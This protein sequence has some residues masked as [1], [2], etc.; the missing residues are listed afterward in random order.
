MI[1]ELT[2]KEIAEWPE[3]FFLIASSP[4]RA[5][6]TFLVNY[7]FSCFPDNYWSAVFCISPT[8]TLQGAF[9][10]VKSEHIVPTKANFG[11]TI[12]RIISFQKARKEANLVLGRVCLILDDLFSS[13]QR[14][15]G[16]G[17]VSGVLEILASRGRHYGISCVLL[18]QR[19]FSIS[20]S[21]RSNAD[22]YISFYPR[23]RK[24]REAIIS[25]YLSRENTGTKADTR[26]RALEVLNFV[27]D[28]KSNSGFRALVVYCDSRERTLEGIC[29]W[30][31]APAVP[32]KWN[33][34]LKH[35]SK[36]ADT[37]AKIEISDLAILE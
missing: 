21:I 4:R 36:A 35:V 13:S 18:S 12:A 30:V 32:K 1:A 20:P 8:S 14:G 24:A 25:T 19:E 23:T 9:S 3:N 31:E 28:S 2:P 10:F 34:V 37:P 16:V 33:L 7:I 26:R 17:A 5:G 29:R 11:P 15:F 22:I 27:F 6:K